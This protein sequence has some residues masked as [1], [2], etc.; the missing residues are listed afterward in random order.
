MGKN[1]T[2][3]IYLGPKET[4]VVA[5]LSYE[6]AAI[7]TR[8]RLKELSGFE[9]ALLSRSSSGLRKRVYSNL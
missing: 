1:K 8:D 3:N 5:R 4:Q 2:G 6:K 7:I 9:N